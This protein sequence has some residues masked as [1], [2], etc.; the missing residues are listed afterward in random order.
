M[1]SKVVTKPGSDQSPIYKWLGSSGRLPQ[2]NF[3][4]Y[5]IGKDGKI[6]YAKVNDNAKEIPPMEEIQGALKAA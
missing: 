4:K 2:W 5:L 1:F 3:A 6:K